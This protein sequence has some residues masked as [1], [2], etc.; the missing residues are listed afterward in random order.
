MAVSVVPQR[1]IALRN[2]LATTL[3]DVPDSR[4]SGQGLSQTNNLLIH[5]VVLLILLAILVVG[6]TGI[7]KRI[8]KWFS[9]TADC[10][11]CDHLPIT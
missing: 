8:E 7:T 10:T 3:V 2:K 5:S 9:R 4:D 1:A 6:I 11:T